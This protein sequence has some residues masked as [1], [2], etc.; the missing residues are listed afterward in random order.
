ML[1]PGSVLLRSSG[2]ASLRI[3]APLLL[4]EGTF[5]CVPGEG[6]AS[7]V[8]SHRLAVSTGGG[9]QREKFKGRTG[10]KGGDPLSFVGRKTSLQFGKTSAPSVKS[11]ACLLFLISCALVHGNGSGWG[12]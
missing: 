11:Q 8:F 1:R 3:T 10:D 5:I 4:G 12:K 9:L 2:E 6:A 7:A